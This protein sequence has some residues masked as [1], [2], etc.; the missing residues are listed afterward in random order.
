MA[1]PLTAD[2]VKWSWERA[3]LPE[4]GARRAGAVLGDIAG[5]TELM[6]GDTGELTGV[7][8]VDDSTLEVALER[9]QPNFPA[10]LA[11]PLASVLSP[12]NVA[13]WGTVNWSELLRGG[14]YESE[15]DLVF[16]ELLVGTGPFRI[17]ELDWETEATLEPNPFYWGGEPQIDSL[18]FRGLFGSVL[19]G[20][21]ELMPCADLTCF[22]PM[23]TLLRVSLTATPGL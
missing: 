11:D 7:T 13:N 8:V 1:S 3:L 5:A 18:T 2:D 19:D 23:P 20:S 12:D 10:L 9:R 6:A 16:D 21:V 22:K 15:W 14:S 17:V 4:T